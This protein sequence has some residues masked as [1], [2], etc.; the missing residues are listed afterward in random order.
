[1]NM[2][3]FSLQLRPDVSVAL[4]PPARVVPMRHGPMPKVQFVVEL[5]GP[6]SVSAAQAAQILSPEWYGALGE[7]EAW[8]MGAADDGWRPLTASVNGAYDS[9]AMA[10][11][12]EGP[13]GQLSVTAAQSLLARTEEFAG[14]IQRRAMAL[15]DPS[16]VGRAV[17]GLR[18]F[19]EALDIGFA[20]VVAPDSGFVSERDL[21]LACARL[22]LELGSTGAFEWRSPTNP[23]PLFSVTPIGVTETF[24]LGAVQ[25]GD[26]H[27][28][29]T[30]GFALPL[31]PS[32]EE[33]LSAAIQAGREIAKH[34]GGHLLDEDGNHVDARTESRLAGELTQAQGL[35]RKAGI[36]PG[37]GEAVRLFGGDA[38]RQ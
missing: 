32:P 34:I 8:C 3:D 9:L 31:C 22:G 25:R 1:M 30:I 4:P 26:V 29:A 2:D 38:A 14:H 21:W 33:A 28:G 37:S 19:R 35:F 18:Q 24:S 17:T 11:D 20:V 27:E 12:L 15:P 6:R 13:R 10:W 7:P 5:V 23:L 36:V 16:D